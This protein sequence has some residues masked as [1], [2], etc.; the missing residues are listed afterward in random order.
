MKDTQYNQN[1]ILRYEHLKQKLTQTHVGILFMYSD[2]K[3]SVFDELK[4]TKTERPYN[5]YR[6]D[7]KWYLESTHTR[8]QV[9]LGD[10]PYKHTITSGMVV[11]LEG[12]IDEK[13][14]LHVTSIM[15]PGYVSDKT[16]KKID[17]SYKILFMSNIRIDNAH[18]KQ[19]LD[20]MLHYIQKHDIQEVIVFGTLFVDNHTLFAQ[21]QKMFD[22]YKVTFVPATN[23]PTTNLLP[24]EPFP[25]RVIGKQNHS[26]PNPCITTINN[27]NFVVSSG[28]IVQDMLRYMPQQ[29]IQ[30]QT[31]DNAK[32]VIQEDI[33][34]ISKRIKTDD[35]DMYNTFCAMD[36]ILQCQYLCPTTPDTL[37]S[38]V[39][40]KKDEF[41]IDKPVHYFV[42]ANTDKFATTKIQNCTHICV[43]NF[44][45][46]NEI[47][48]FD[49]KDSKHETI[50]YE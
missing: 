50:K 46:T 42:N 48:I 11:G 35:N 30:K 2:N 37:K 47:V 3:P 36:A 8:R 29:D 31:I 32:A 20:V 27:H 10:L 9:V 13:D 4:Y 6:E 18:N 21:L 15:Y 24:Q 7:A 34:N 14:V 45:T 44:D 17:A 22:S 12:T 33:D 41:V 26:L 38:V 43:P 5:Y 1:Y 16:S 19:K 23:D 28:E 40:D 25:N 49:M 39:F